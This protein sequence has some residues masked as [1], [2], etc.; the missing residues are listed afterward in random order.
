MLSYIL[1]GGLVLYLMRSAPATSP[2][3]P[4]GGGPAGRAPAGGWGS[5][6]NPNLYPLAA[7]GFEPPTA[8]AT[9]ARAPFVALTSA[10]GTPL[11][12]VPFAKQLE[13][14][15][16]YETGHFR[17]GQFASTGSPGM[18]VFS[19]SF[20]YGWSSLE[21]FATLKRI[22]SSRFGISRRFTVSGKYYWYVAFPSVSTAVEF[23]AWYIKEK[24]AGNFGAWASRLASEQSAYVA[25]ISAV[26][27]QFN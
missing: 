19:P 17:S 6:T 5:T 12:S 15:F 10:V 8:T 11:Y 25:S 2:T 9:D 23:L 22:P 21:E 27:A 1:A 16:R 14:L 20:P 13:R 26:T 18:R 4:A 3:L 24:K 7:S